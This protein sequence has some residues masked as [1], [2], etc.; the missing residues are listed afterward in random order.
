MGQF[1]FWGRGKILRPRGNTPDRKEIAKKEKISS[2]L[3]LTAELS[4][5]LYHVVARIVDTTNKWLLFR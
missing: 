1:F 4:Q 2:R 3:T 5:L